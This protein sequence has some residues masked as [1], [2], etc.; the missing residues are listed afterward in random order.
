MNKT[1]SGTICLRHSLLSATAISLKS[2][3]MFLTHT[4]KQ[5]KQD[6]ATDNIPLSFLCIVGPLLSVAVAKGESHKNVFDPKHILTP[7][8]YGIHFFQD[9]CVFVFILTY[10][11]HCTSEYFLPK[12][13][14]NNSFCAL[15]T[16][17]ISKHS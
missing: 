4:H 14:K 9:H 7:K 11:T 12:N 8:N 5:W 3:S 17:K 13:K 6:R 2:F 1:Y 16:G 10:V 15:F